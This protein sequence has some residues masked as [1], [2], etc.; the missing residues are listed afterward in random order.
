MIGAAATTSARSV[1]IMTTK[2]F[3][4]TGVMREAIG[5]IEVS[6]GLLHQRHTLV[7]VVLHQRADFVLDL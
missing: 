1:I 6:A 5:I 7:E 2:T 4:F 3:P